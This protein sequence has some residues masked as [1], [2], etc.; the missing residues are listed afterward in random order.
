LE[1]KGESRTPDWS[2]MLLQHSLLSFAVLDQHQLPLHFTFL[3]RC[4]L[5]SLPFI[6]TMTARRTSCFSLPS[7]SP[8]TPHTTHRFGIGEPSDQDQ[9]SPWRIFHP[10]RSVRA[11]TRTR[12]RARAWPRPSSVLS[13]VHGQCFNQMSFYCRILTS[14]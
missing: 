3:Q 9:Y 11:R 6:C 14:Y 2:H 7:P 1:L 8:S 4:S 5:C 10:R 13:S 12:T